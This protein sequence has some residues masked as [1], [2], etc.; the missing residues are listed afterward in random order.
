MNASAMYSP[1]EAETE[2]RR[3]V[4]RTKGQRQG[5]ITRL[6]SP[7]DLGQLLKP[8]VFLDYGVIP[9]PGGKLFGIHPHS[10]IATLTVPLTGG[11]EYFDTTGK[12]GRVPARGLEWMK[13]G[14]GAWHDGSIYSEDPLEFFQLWLALP[15]D[16][17]LTPAESQY[18]ERSEVQSVGP[19]RV[20]LGHYEGASSTI[21]APVGINYF[22]VELADGEVWRFKP[23]VGHTVG[24]LAVNAGS[25][26]LPELASTGE[27][28][29]LDS[30]DGVIEIEAHGSTSLVVGTAVPHPYPLVTG[31]YSVHTNSDALERGEL[32]IAR[33]G[34]E[35]RAAG[36]LR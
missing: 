9:S 2:A 21:K 31:Y 12:A 3:I 35:L 11:F 33:I 1:H 14:S 28:V 24:W 20:L 10:G 17:E 32:E 13:A 27:L 8:F 15:E 4:F 5:P 19:V 18:V 25:A 26:L 36:R 30:S 16:W 7:S 22:H 29:V 34:E 23:P 6:V